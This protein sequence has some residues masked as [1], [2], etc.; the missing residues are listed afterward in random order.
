MGNM[1]ERFE[2]V[3]FDDDQQDVSATIRDSFGELAEQ[4]DNLLTDS[5]EKSLAITNLEQARFWVNASIARNP[6]E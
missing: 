6:M 1:A 3:D 4:I 2:S 5:R